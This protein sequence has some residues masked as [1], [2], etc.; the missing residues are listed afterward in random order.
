MTVRETWH[1]GDLL[2]VDNILNAHGREAFSGARK[3]LVAMGDP[4][5][6][7]DCSPQTAPSTTV[8]DGK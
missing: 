4:V 2:M 3:I 7:A 1:V 8:S 6:L 5:S